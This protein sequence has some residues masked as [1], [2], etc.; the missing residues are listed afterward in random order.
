MIRVISSSGIA[1]L[2]QL[3][4]K[5]YEMN[6]D[7]QVANRPSY[8]SD[9]HLSSQL[10]YHPDTGTGLWTSLLIILPA[11]TFTPIQYLTPSLDLAGTAILLSLLQKKI[12]WALQDILE[13][14]V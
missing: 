8:I 2:L 11:P 7:I 3:M 10:K 1:T 6:V 14:D 13:E 5:R 12:P 4:R 9:F